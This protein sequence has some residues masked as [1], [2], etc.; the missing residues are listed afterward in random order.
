MKRFLTVLLTVALTLSLTGC[1]AKE[2]AALPED[3]TVVTGGDFCPGKLV[4]PEG[5]PMTPAAGFDETEDMSF[6]TVDVHG[7]TVT[8]DIFAGTDRGI[9]VVFWLA[10]SDKSAAELIKL[11][12][13]TDKAAEYGYKILGV[14]MDGEKHAD[15]ARELAGELTFDNIIWNDSM[16]LRYDGVWKFF[17]PEFYEENAENFA[18]L[19]SAPALG[20]PISTRTNSRGQIQTS[21]ALVPLSEEK[22]TETWKDNDSNA[23]YEELV[24]EGQNIVKGN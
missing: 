10:D 20:N 24:A 21:C 1:G 15:K 8:N 13:L 2:E 16:A 9:W 18:G 17:T 7:N 4:G 12:G 19:D 5:T 6:T 22:L 14:V 3:T 11:D 23:T